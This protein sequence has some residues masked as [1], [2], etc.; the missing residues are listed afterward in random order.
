MAQVPAV[1]PLGSDS[2]APAVPADTPAV[3]PLGS[4]SSAAK[5]PV[6]TATSQRGVA[7]ETAESFETLD[8]SVVEA[9]D[10]GK[11]PQPLGTAPP[12]SSHTRDQLY[13][14]ASTQAGYELPPMELLR[15]APHI[16]GEEAHLAQRSAIIEATLRSFNIDAQCVNAVVGPR[17][18]RYEL[19]IGPGIN[20]SK[21]LALSDNL[22]LELAVK[23]VRI[24]APIPGKRAVGIEVPNAAPQLVTLRSILSTPLMQRS[25][26][27]LTVAIGRDIA[28]NP[29]IVNLAKTPHLLVAGSAGSGKSVCLNTLIVSLLMRNA[30]DT[31]RLIMIDPKRVELTGYDGIPHL[32]CPVVCDVNQ[33]QNALKWVVAEMD[34]R[35]RVL[36]ARRARNIAAFNETAEP[37]ERLPFIVVILDEL[38]DLMMLAGQTVEKLIARITQLS[39]A[40]GIHMVI[41][42]Q[43]PDVKVITGTIK[44]NVPSRIAFAVVS[45]VDSRTILDGAGAEKLLG[46][47]DML[48]SP[49]G[50][51]VPLRVQGCFLADDEID[52]VV[53]HTQNQAA[54]T[55]DESILSFG[56]REDGTPGAAH[57]VPVLDLD[58][59]LSSDYEASDPDRDPLFN[60][61]RGIVLDTG[62][63]STSYLQRR[64]K[65]G[66]NRAARIM[67]ELQDAGIVSEPD[68]RGD[69]KVL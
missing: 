33:A 51:N 68:V 37:H 6:T 23:A 62:K 64:L 13:L 27:P 17:V 54:A 50:E 15:D 36:Q 40:V 19:T 49:I 35:Y 21:I 41:A 34:R 22:A 66:Y 42:T 52:R 69:R 10:S 47:G 65:I 43:R 4:K 48:F 30:P 55:L 45:N 29:V 20:V 38:A 67:E 31:L 28:G 58:G 12:S 39:R 59:T 14:F 24:E 5:A 63:A 18:T 25:N 46:G 44:A 2:P 26:H 8:A 60:E 9:P 1:R 61:A 32:A 16:A 7:A 3:K 11:P 57:D 53:Q 56:A